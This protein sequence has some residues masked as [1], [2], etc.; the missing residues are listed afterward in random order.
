MIHFL[1]VEFAFPDTS[2]AYD[3][4]QAAPADSRKTALKFVAGEEL[5][6]AGVHLN[7]P[8]FGRVVSNG[9][10]YRFIPE[11]WPPTI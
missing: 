10:A 4:D 6:V 9:A 1:C 8:T 2:I 11:V 5:R 7:F 3:I